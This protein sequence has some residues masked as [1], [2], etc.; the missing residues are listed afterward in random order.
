[1]VQYD[2]DGN[3]REVKFKPYSYPD[4]IH[5]NGTPREISGNTE[6]NK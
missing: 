5:T 2:S 1:M 3:G 4:M 6:V